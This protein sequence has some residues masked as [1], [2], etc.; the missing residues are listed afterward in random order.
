MIEQIGQNRS[1]ATDFEQTMLSEHAKKKKLAKGFLNNAGIFVGVLLMFAVIVVVTT[2]IRLTSFEEIAA[3]GLDFFLLLFVSYSMYVNCS[4]SGMRAGLQSETY[5]GGLKAFETL[6]KHIIDTKMQARLGEFCC[7]YITE[8]LRNS[9]TTVLAIVGFSYEE[10]M[11]KYVGKDTETIQKDK[12]LSKAQKKAII[13]ANGIEP[14]KLTPEMIMK[15][16]RGSSRRAPLGTT[17][18]TKKGINFGTK[19]VSTFIISLA[20]SIIVLEAVVEPTWVLIATCCLKLMAVVIN[21]FNGYKFGYE[22]IVFDT[23]NY[24]SDQTDLMTQAVQYVEGHPIMVSVA[25]ES[26]ADAEAPAEE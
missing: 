7:H 21:G 10:Y 8:E 25:K 13:K 9:R 22:N 16:G 17:P 2:D 6:K 15:R 1:S 11:E 18:E 23:V 19:F 26:E 5:T 12:T 20:M 3:L 24:M 4:D 14:V